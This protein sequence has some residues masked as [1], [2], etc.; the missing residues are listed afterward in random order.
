MS[1]EWTI[2]VPADDDGAEAWQQYYDTIIAMD[3]FDHHHGTDLVGETLQAIYGN[4]M[5]SRGKPSSGS[6]R[7]SQPRTAAR[8]NGHRA[9]CLLGRDA[10]TGDYW[11][12]V[13]IGNVE[14]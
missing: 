9:C 2:E 1:G 5:S 10:P 8:T 11:E 14:L 13:R 7:R 12:K 4:E 3:Q 6:R